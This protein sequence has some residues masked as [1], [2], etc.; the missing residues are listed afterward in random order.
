MGARTVI[1]TW[2]HGDQQFENLSRMGT[3]KVTQA[4]DM[5]TIKFRWHENMGNNWNIKSQGDETWGLANSGGTK[6]GD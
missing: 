3:R 4:C 6:H 2:A 5:G 1:Q